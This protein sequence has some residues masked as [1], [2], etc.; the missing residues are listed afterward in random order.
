MTIQEMSG[1]FKTP[2]G[3]MAV[4]ELDGVVSGGSAEDFVAD[5]TIARIIEE[6]KVGYYDERI[7]KNAVSVI[8]EKCTIDDKGKVVP[9]GEAVQVPLGM[10]DRIATPYK[11]EADGTVIRDAGKESV[12]AAGTTVADWKKAPNAKAFMTA[13]VGKAI[14]FEVAATVNVRAWDRAANALSKTEL[15]EQKVYSINWVE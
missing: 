12:R 8:M 6:S 11:K 15:R 1:K 3:T 9:T 5:G 10:F 2:N 7:S 14:K 13:N 4:R